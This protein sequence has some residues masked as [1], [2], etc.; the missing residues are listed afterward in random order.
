MQKPTFVFKDVEVDFRL[1]KLNSKKHD[2]VIGKKRETITFDYPSNFLD[3]KK[4]RTAAIANFIHASDSE[5][6][7]NLIYPLYSVHDSLLVGIKNFCY[8][9]DDYE[10]ALNKTSGRLI[11]N[12]NNKI[13][14]SLFL[15][16]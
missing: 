15:L 10:N 12:K 16:I 5:T 8:V 13:V 11:F 14:S 6:L 7:R 9:L 2:Y 1:Y 3:E 4:T